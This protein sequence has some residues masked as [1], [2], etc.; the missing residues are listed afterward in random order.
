[1]RYL[2]RPVFWP[3]ARRAWPALALLWA[4]AVQALPAP[5]LVCPSVSPAPPGTVNNVNSVLNTLAVDATN[6]GNQPRWEVAVGVT[7]PA[8]APP[9]PQPADIPAAVPALTFNYLTGTEIPGYAGGLN[10]TQSK[11][12]VGYYPYPAGYGVPA[13]MYFRYRFKLDPTVDPAGYQLTL[14][15]IWA[16]DSVKAIY[17]NGQKWTGPWTPTTYGGPG[18]SAVLGGGANSPQWNAGDNEVTL[19]VYDSGGAVRMRVGEASAR[20]LAGPVA[21]TIAPAP[22]VTPSQPVPLSGTV[23]GVANG[24]TITVTVV[25]S[26]GV[27]STYSAIAA[28]GA[29][30]VTVPGG[31]LPA[32]TYQVT[33][34]TP[35]GLTATTQGAVLAPALTPAPL[36][37]SVA[38]SDTVT[39]AGTLTHVPAGTLVTVVLTG[40]NGPTTYTAVTDAAGNYGP[41]AAGPLP[42]GAYTVATSAAGLT[43]APQAFTVRAVAA[44]A[45]V[46]GVPTLEAWA[47][48]LLGTLMAALA[49]WRR[50]GA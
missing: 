17:I 2:S 28:N 31:T 18:A 16:D 24:A 23:A 48:G 49:G 25:D 8:P 13:Q 14:N 11:T 3:L 39:L 29:W 9:A 26:A 6:R 42:A 46:Q 27:P 36:P 34:T 12:T 19:L 10:S 15:D 22:T 7:T 45:G 37:P 1:M 38:P 44:G 32:G 35:S 5:V 40:P 20:C 41:I 50:R 43:A 47:L 21:I 33:A 30:S 4:A